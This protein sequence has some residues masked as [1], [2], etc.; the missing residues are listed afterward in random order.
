MMHLKQE[1]LQFCII[2]VSDSFG[3]AIYLSSF[4]EEEATTS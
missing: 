1:Q 3:D 2:I 4:V